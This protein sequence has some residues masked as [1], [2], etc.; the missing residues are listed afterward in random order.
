MPTSTAQNKK[1]MLNTLTWVLLKTKLMTTAE[2]FCSSPVPSVLNWCK[3]DSEFT[4]S[5][6]KI[7]VLNRSSLSLLYLYYYL[8]MY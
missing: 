5:N 3:K 7:T 8:H 1:T 4:R 6:L 2:F